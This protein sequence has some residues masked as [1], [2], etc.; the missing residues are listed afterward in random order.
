MYSPFAAGQRI[1]F[2]S[3]AKV[4]H[5]MRVFGGT[6][7]ELRDAAATVGI[8][9]VNIQQY[10]EAEQQ[11]QL[12][13]EPKNC[14]SQ[15]LASDYPALTSAERLWYPYYLSSIGCFLAAA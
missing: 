14:S 5:W 4:T 1:D 11:K 6:H 12:E 9:L 13:A 2:R 7:L 3:E 15:A 10:V 8:G